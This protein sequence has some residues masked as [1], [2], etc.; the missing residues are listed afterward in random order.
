[1]EL[2]K[3]FIIPLA[4]LVV[5]L[6]IWFREYRRRIRWNEIGSGENRKPSFVGT[7][8]GRK[9]LI[10]FGSKAETSV[11]WYFLREKERILGRGSI[12]ELM[13]IAERVNRVR[14][15]TRHPQAVS[16]VVDRVGAGRE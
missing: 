8:K 1:M 11:P 15:S 14:G 5:G 4:P 6:L 12:A 10:E 3:D 2:V 13:E 16:A 9:F 7:S